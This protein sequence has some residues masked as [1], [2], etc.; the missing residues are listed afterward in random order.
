MAVFRTLSNIHDGAF[1]GKY[2]KVMSDIFLRFC[3][4][5][6]QDS[7]SKTRKDVF[8]FSSEALFALEIF[9]FLNFEI[10]N[11]EIL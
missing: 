10:W 4:V 11:F 7:T 6:L 3:F 2:L 9:K 8:Y 5:S 1:Y